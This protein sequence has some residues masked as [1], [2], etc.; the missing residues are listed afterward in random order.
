MDIYVGTLSVDD[1]NKNQKI[2]LS[3]DKIKSVI[4]DTDDLKIELDGLTRTVSVTRTR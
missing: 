4:I 2:V 3:L 1:L